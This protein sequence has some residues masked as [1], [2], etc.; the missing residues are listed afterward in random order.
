MGF[1][2]NL[3]AGGAGNLVE[4]VG[5]AVDKLTT[6]KGEKM[7]L[8]LEQQKAEREFQVEMAKLDVE[9]EKNRLQDTQSARQ[10]QTAALAQDDRFSKRFVAYLTIG[11]VILSFAYIFMITFIDIPE[12]NQR[13]ADTI[14]GVIIGLIIGSIYTFWFGSSAGSGKKTEAL[15]NGMKERK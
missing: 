7:Q 11:S 8:E 9:E 13:F 1:L 12:K 4:Q 15:I 3:L 5:N 10:M 2:Q 14:L 6:T